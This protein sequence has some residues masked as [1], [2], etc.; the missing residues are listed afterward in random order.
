[1]KKTPFDSLSLIPAIIAERVVQ[2]VYTCPELSEKCKSQKQIA[3]IEALRQLLSPAQI[4]E[5]SDRCEDIC[6]SA[7]EAN[8]SWFLECVKAKGNKGRNQLYIW[9]SQEMVSYL[10]RPEKFLKRSS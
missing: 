1:M 3:K 8:R 4:R 7:Y 10:L 5:F 9:I 6:R 2:S